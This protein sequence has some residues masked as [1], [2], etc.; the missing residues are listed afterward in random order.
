MSLIKEPG[1]DVET[2]GSQVIEKTSHI[3]GS[4]PAPSNI[5]SIFAQCFIECSVIAFKLKTLQFCDIVDDD[6]TGMEWDATA[7][8]IKTKYQSIESQDLWSTKA[9]NAKK[10]SNELTGIHAKVNKLTTQV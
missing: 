9:M 10:N 3:I 1:K 7:Q 8:K 6:P 5:T 2:F 4:G